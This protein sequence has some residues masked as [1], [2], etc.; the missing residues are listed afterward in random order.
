MTVGELFNK[1]KEVCATANTDQPFMCLDLSYMSV[2]LKDGY[3][4]KPRTTIKVME[5]L[6]FIKT[7][8]TLY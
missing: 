2:L 1:A 7:G 4:L 8:L 3:D 5:I 6:E